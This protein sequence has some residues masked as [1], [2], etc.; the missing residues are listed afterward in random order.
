MRARR[1]PHVP[2]SPPAP[3]PL[4]P[5]VRALAATGAAL[6][7]AGVVLVAAP[8]RAAADVVHELGWTAT[9]AG[10]SSWYGSYGM[11]GLGSAWCIDHGSAAPDADL[12][13]VPADL[14]AVP[15]DTQAAM[16]WAIGRAG[17][18]PDR[19]DAAALMLVLHDL[20]EATY[21]DGPLDVDTMTAADLSGFD[22]AEAS[23][24][25][26]ARA[27]KAD[28]VAHAGV[29]GPLV[30]TASVD[31]VDPGAAGTL[32]VSVAGTGGAG[33]AGVVVHATATGATL[34]GAAEATTDARGTATFP[35]TA[36][37][38]ENR[39]AATASAPDPV[40]HA[41]TSSTAPAQRVAVPAVVQLTATARFA[42]TPS[43]ITVH[44]TGD[45]TAYL[46]LTGARFEVRPAGADGHHGGEPVGTLVTDAAGATEA[47][48]VP[49]GSYVVHEVEPPPGYAPAGPWR[50]DVAAGEAA[51]VE[52]A[53]RSH[54]G[55]ARI[56]K[57]DATTGRP[58]AGATLALAYDADA[59][60]TFETELDP[61]VTGD[62]PAEARLRV[63]HYRLTEVT[64]PE[65][66][67]G[68]DHPIEFNVGAGERMT[69]TVENAP[70]A[71][72]A[73]RKVPSGPVDPDHVVLAGAVF[74][75]RPEGGGEEV[76]RCTT[77]LHGRCALPRGAVEAG[78]RY[79]WEELSAPPGFGTAEPGCVEAGGA[80]EVTTVEVEE[81]S[82]H[83][84]V[85][86]DKRDAETG[87]PVEG[88]TYDLYRRGGPPAGRLPSP[89]P[90]EG[91]G[92]VD[93]ATWVATATS[94][95]RGRVPWG[96][97]LPGFVYCAAERRAPEGYRLDPTLRCTAGPLEAGEPAVIRLPDQPVPPPT[98]S[99]TTSTT[100]PTTT[101]TTVPP[102]TGPS[103][104]VPP[105]TIPGPTPPPTF[106]GP[107]PVPTWPATTVPS[108]APPPPTS[109][110]MTG[111]AS[112]TAGMA[113]VGGGLVLLGAAVLGARPGDRR[114]RPLLPTAAGDG[115]PVTPP[116]RPEWPRGAVPRPPAGPAARLAGRWRRPA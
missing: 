81:P 94:D 46:P 106:G 13:Y 38:G 102:T 93:G 28:A 44:K 24:V 27:I 32:R 72:I 42:P 2:P 7:L 107:T 17:T 55:R 73:F 103:T 80:G 89:A 8:R 50:V 15:A 105:T 31:P 111:A 86:G 34:T 49:P 47:L 56:E 43:T 108:P 40:L 59:D 90:P 57:I 51:T 53:D 100:V 115:G 99:T 1:R 52:V 19:V 30:M 35:F 78:A 85:T 11:A 10:W 71:T 114:R 88:A 61:I 87:E 54:P 97:Q 36:G 75:V 22:G 113:S 66:Y 23:V 92:P 91:A 18:A 68:L 20:M 14:S 74:A 45:A 69:V 21:P 83:T 16:A 33:V 12:G 96:L 41:Y 112:R 29:R 39:F 4:P 110:P 64:T 84:E 95:D 65:G 98:T 6:V 101:S 3:V 60:G 5:W 9:V 67:E 82:E 76:G 116:V 77:D 58:V 26:R 79:C 37:P 48:A 25:A 104:T 63:G 109:L 70:Q 62:G